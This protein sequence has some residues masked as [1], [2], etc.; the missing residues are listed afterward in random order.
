MVTLFKKEHYP[1]SNS[2]RSNGT[3]IATTCSHDCPSVCSL[4]VERIDSHTIGRVR[5]A[6][7][8]TYTAG[9]T[10]AKTARYAERTHHPDRLKTPLIR[11]GA[12][13]DGIFEA[14]SWE[15]ALDTVAEAFTKSA[16]ADGT[17]AV[18]PFHSGGTMGLVQ[19]YGLERLRNVMGYSREHT[20]ICITPAKSGWE[21]GVGALFGPDPREMAEADMIVAWGTN[22]VSTQINAMTHIQR[23]RK[24]RGARLIVVDVYRNP[25]VET[26]DLALIIR[27]GTDGALA[28]AVMN[29]LLKEGYADRDYLAR[30]SDF[31]EEVEAH[32][33]AKTP[34]WAA[35][36]TGLSEDEIFAFARE[37]GK[38]K[39]SFIRVGL[40]FSRSHNGA[41]NLHAVTCLP[42]VTGAWKHRG[43]G[44]FLIGVGIWKLDNTLIRGLDALKPNTR[45][46][47]Q[48][49]VGAVLTGETEALCDGPPVTAMLIQ[50]ANIAVT[51]PDTGAVLRG[52]SREDLF[53]CVHEQFMTPTAQMADV[54]LPATTFVEHD[55]LYLGLG[56]T[57]LSLGPKVIEPVGES[58]SNHD[59]VCGLAERLGAEHPGFQLS[60]WE[61]IDATLRASNLVDAETMRKNKWIDGALEFDEAHFANGFPNKSGRFRFKPD[62]A[63][64]GPLHEGLPSLPDH[65]PLTN[66]TDKDHAFRMVTPPAR[67]FLN[68]SFAE[69]ST[70]RDR[71]G[72]PR[73]LIHPEDADRLGIR[74]RTQIIVGNLQGSVH[75]QVCH[76]SGLQPGVV[77]AE[78]VWPNDQFKNGIGINLLINSRPIAPNY[79]AAFHDTAVWI[80]PG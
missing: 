7:G 42:T 5:G 29:I 6:K 38:T 13:G 74:D 17:E 65:A 51:S 58:R 62:W 52:L 26:A 2:T 40:G 34:A 3:F 36:I 47:D 24:E 33:A 50:N 30:L 32:L 43:G 59:M 53:T 75:L 70:S 78:S 73:L 19:R 69:T 16:Q 21:A 60:A 72:Q 10:C 11:R 27:P 49:R 56:H 23:A 12:K 1:Q 77:M 22:L 48:S 66:V 44:A 15:S 35:A 25:T 4:E 41:S 71:E 20:S 39:R 8:N 45:I 46:L 54:V 57:F 61:M 55:D 63:A 18:W 80:R 64:I 31:D 9:V 68:T 79:G 28:C 76:F 37:Y 14:V 67:N